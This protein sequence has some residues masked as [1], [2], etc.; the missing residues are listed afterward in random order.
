M[1]RSLN[2]QLLRRMFA[3]WL[4]ASLAAGGVVFYFEMDKVDEQVLRLGMN[5]AYAIEQPVIEQI[6]EIGATSLVFLERLATKLIEGDFVIVEIYDKSKKHLAAAVRHDS[7]KA[8]RI[9]ERKTHQFPLDNTVHY[10]KFYIDQNLYTQVL[11]PLRSQHGDVHGYFEGVYRVDAETLNEIQTHVYTTLLVVLS[12]LLATFVMLYP[13]ILYLNRQLILF[14]N[15]LFNANVEL[16]DVMGSAI[17][18]R[19]SIT[20][21]HN[22]RVTLY[23]LRLGEMLSLDDESMGN[24][25]AGAFFH[26]VGKIGIEDSILCKPGRLTESEFDRMKEHVVIGIDII[27]KASWLQGARDVIEFHHEKY[28]GSG[29]M[30]GLHGDD[31]PLAARIFTLADVF[32]ALI[33][34]RPYKQALPLEKVMALM[35]QESGKQFDPT[36]LVLFL[37]MAPGLYKNIGKASYSSLTRMLS[38]AVQKYFFKARLK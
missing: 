36:L 25:L 18:K 20:D 27:S 2:T 4:L 14:S 11:V 13:V 5:G 1:N 37:S 34:E 33:T 32:D 31:I 19:D 17:A 3:L 6:P 10:E 12:V 24:L 15:D 28:D 38:V 30:R 21:S 35:Q 23:A 22:Y 8:D 16:M 7:E 26:D 29:Y 9:L